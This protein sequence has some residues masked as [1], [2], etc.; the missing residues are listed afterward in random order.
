MGGVVPT[1]PANPYSICFCTL[2]VSRA[3][4]SA[5]VAIWLTVAPI[6][7][8]IVITVPQAGP[9]THAPLKN[10]FVCGLVVPNPEGSG[11]PVNVQL[12]ALPLSCSMPPKDTLSD[13]TSTSLFRLP[14]SA[15]LRNW[16]VA[17]P[18]PPEVIV[19]VTL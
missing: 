17:G 9:P 12:L 14:H 13:V 8:V 6:E 5:W 4:C 18:V 7:P 15:G 19:P 3:S 1:S 2:S 10:T 16:Q 11:A